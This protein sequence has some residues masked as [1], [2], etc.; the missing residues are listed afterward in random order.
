MLLP[1]AAQLSAELYRCC[2]Q[3][4]RPDIVSSPDVVSR[5][6]EFVPLLCLAFVPDLF[7]PLHLWLFGD[8][9]SGVNGV[10]SEKGGNL[11]LLLAIT[12]EGLYQV[13]EF[14]I[15]LVQ[16]PLQVLPRFLQQRQELCHLSAVCLTASGCVMLTQ[17]RAERKV[18]EH[19]QC[20]VHTPQQWSP[21]APKH[22]PFT[23]QH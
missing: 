3:Q 23:F 15:S 22:I 13:L 5:R 1:S 8:N 17:G 20:V 10:L 18:S 19:T 11:V 14:I 2:F 16:L 21:S 4:V 12:G 6:T 7:C 9:K